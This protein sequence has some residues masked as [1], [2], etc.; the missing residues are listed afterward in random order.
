MGTQDVQS[1]SVTLHIN[2][3]SQSHIT[4]PHGIIK[5]YPLSADD[6]KSVGW[7]IYVHKN[8]REHSSKMYTTQMCNQYNLQ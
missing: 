2:L 7:S 5:T 3:M 4:F 6:M 1:D 8:K